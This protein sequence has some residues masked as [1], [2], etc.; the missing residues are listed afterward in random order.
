[1]NKFTIIKY[2]IIKNTTKS[3]NLNQQQSNKDKLKYHKSEPQIAEKENC[4]VWV[5]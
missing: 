1:M 5:V 2:K 4:N 3:T